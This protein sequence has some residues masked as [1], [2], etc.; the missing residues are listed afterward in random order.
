MRRAQPPNPSEVTMPGPPPERS[1][2]RRRRNKGD[3]PEVVKAPGGQAPEVPPLT[4][5]G[6]PSQRVE[7]TT[8]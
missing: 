4:R 2:Q 5:V 6:I 1:D 8:C 7:A 3:A